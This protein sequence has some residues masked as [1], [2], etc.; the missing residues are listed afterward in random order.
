[1]PGNADDSEF[2]IAS[3]EIALASGFAGTSRKSTP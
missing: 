3:W 1:M 2:R